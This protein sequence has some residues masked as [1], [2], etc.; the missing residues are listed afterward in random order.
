MKREARYDLAILEQA[1]L[2]HMFETKA[3]LNVLERKGL[4]TV[5]EVCEEIRRLKEQAAKGSIGREGHACS[6]NPRHVGKPGASV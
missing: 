3:L 2:A 5:A 4:V 6:N 1:L